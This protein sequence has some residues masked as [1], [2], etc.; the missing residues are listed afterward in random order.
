[1][2][3]ELLRDPEIHLQ[4]SF[5]VGCAKAPRYPWLVLSGSLKVMR[6]PGGKEVLLGP[7]AFFIT[8]I[9]DLVA[10]EVRDLHA[11]H[12][13]SHSVRSNSAI[14]WP[15]F[16]RPCARCVPRRSSFMSRS[17]SNVSLGLMSS[18]ARTNRRFSL[19]VS[20]YWPSSR[21]ERYFSFGVQT[22][23]LAQERFLEAGTSW[24]AGRTSGP[25]RRC[26]RRRY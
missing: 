7:A 26:H 9:G 8:H 25:H 12:S 17:C 5:A 13:K 24:V 16:P 6:D 22:D 10:Y 14:R 3:C 11:G 2:R 21:S 23:G 19:L 1:M 15:P 18:A 20:T 4:R